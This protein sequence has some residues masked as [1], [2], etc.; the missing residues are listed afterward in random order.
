LAK[1]NAGKF[2]ARKG[3]SF[4]V[5]WDLEWMGELIEKKVEAAIL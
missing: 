3:R 2:E 5:I 4:L 1:K